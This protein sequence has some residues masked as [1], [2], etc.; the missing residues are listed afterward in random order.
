MTA[1]DPLSLRLKA[2][3]AKYAAG[4]ELDV[5]AVI[6][7][8]TELGSIIRWQDGTVGEVGITGDQPETLLPLIIDRLRVL[9]A[10]PNNNR[11]TAS[12]ITRIEEGLHWLQARRVDRLQRG[13]EG[14]N[15]R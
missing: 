14:T 12:A 1:T 4:G 9:N 15:Q 5:P 7:V 10:N 11:E 6:F 3:T 8:A 2:E 13:V